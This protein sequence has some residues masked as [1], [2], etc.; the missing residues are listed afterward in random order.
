MVSI[1][2][3]AE[4]DSSP[5]NERET[6]LYRQLPSA[7]ASNGNHCLKSDG[8]SALDKKSMHRCFRSALSFVAVTEAGKESCLISLGQPVY[9]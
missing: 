1:R 2:R 6:E 3:K 9:L 8:R 7:L 4:R 5:T